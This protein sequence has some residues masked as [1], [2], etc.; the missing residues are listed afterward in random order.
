M[1]QFQVIVEVRG[2]VTYHIKAEEQ[3]EAENIAIEYA[4]DGMGLRTIDQFIPEIY[5]CVDES[6]EM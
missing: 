5:D 2:L 4:N 3:E 1:K 6:E